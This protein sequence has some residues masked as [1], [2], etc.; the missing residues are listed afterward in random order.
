MSRIQTPQA[1]FLVL[2][3]RFSRV[4]YT[5]PPVR[6][7]GLGVGV[8]LFCYHP[9]RRKWQQPLNNTRFKE[10]R[11]RSRHVHRTDGASMKKSGSKHRVVRCTIDSEVR[12]SLTA[13]LFLRFWHYPPSS[14]CLAR[15]GLP[16]R[17]FLCRATT[18][19]E[20]EFCR[21]V[22]WLRIVVSA[23]KP[24]CLPAARSVLPFSVRFLK[25]S[26]AR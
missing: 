3:N 9:S 24:L 8:R 1:L 7:L 26:M 25:A 20:F 22:G 4:V 23:W 17:A 6:Y 15:G 21:P 18:T 16:A 2:L 13:T 5:P 19:F 10:W 11:K 12:V 14:L